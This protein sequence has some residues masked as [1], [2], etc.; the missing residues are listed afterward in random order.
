MRKVFKTCTISDKYRRE[1]IL[2]N[3]YVG[4]YID[5]DDSMYILTHKPCR[6]NHKRQENLRIH[7]E[8]RRLP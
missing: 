8:A 2:C 3:G 1:L 7:Q 5:F 4:H 6:M